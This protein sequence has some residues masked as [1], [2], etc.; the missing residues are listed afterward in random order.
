MGFEAARPLQAPFL[1]GKKVMVEAQPT[2]PA[3]LAIG[4]TDPCGAYGVMADLKTFAA[5]RVHGQAVVSVVT[6]QNSRGWHGAAPIE[7]EMIGRQL[8]AVLDDY[9]AAAIKTGFLGRGEVIELIGERIKQYEKAAVV[10]DPVLV[11]GHG[12]PMFDADV[13]E[14]FKTF[15]L[16]LATV[17]T[18]NRWEARLLMGRGLET[19]IDW[20][21]AA[22]DLASLAPQ[23][24]W[25]V[26]REAA[27]GDWGD[28]LFSADNALFLP[29]AHIATRNTAGSGDTLAAAV[30]AGLGR[31]HAILKAIRDAQRYTHEAIARAAGWAL[32]RGSGP[33]P[34]GN[35]FPFDK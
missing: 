23:A 30:A 22:S 8:D 12:R 33:G 18:P 34:I 15:L 17:V 25:L 1:V 28:W 19:E 13:V 21:A 3:V 9:G 24:V 26:K 31:G 32:A 35:F 16:P 2:P 4:G 14:A 27:A 10:V 5:F 6:A 29:Q 11:N 20:P 7:V